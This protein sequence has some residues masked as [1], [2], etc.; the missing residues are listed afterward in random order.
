MVRQVDN[1]NHDLLKL[2]RIS[3][4]TTKNTKNV[5]DIRVMLEYYVI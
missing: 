3:F 2:N 4:T 1:M 5:Q